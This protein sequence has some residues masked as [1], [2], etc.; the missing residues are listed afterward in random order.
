[1]TNIVML[2]HNRHRLTEQALSTLYKYTPRDQFNLTLV[3]DASSDFRA[4]RY[5]ELA[6]MNANTCLLRIEKSKGI[7]GQAR[8]LGIYWARRFFGKGDWLYLSDND[9]AFTE[10]WLEKLIAVAIEAE[11]YGYKLMGGQVHPY[12]QAITE[13]GSYLA[14][15]KHGPKVYSPNYTGHVAIDGPSW[16]MRWP[17]WSKYG[18]LSMNAPGVCQGEDGEFCD[19]I[20]ADGGRL[21]VINPHVVIHCGLTNSHGKEGP[22][23]DIRRQSMVPGVLYE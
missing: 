23:A 12:H 15:D 16:L 3:N 2:V 11:P 22:G 21:G 10:G 1:M 19:K 20:R 8:N 6:A 7:T 9:V 5:L 14:A 18:P 13:G 17:V 4:N